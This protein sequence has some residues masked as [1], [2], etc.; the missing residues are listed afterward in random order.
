M[1]RP[2]LVIAILTASASGK[3]ADDWLTGLTDKVIDD[4]AAGKPLVVEVHVP[5]CESSIIACGNA[6]LGD[7]DNPDTNLYWSTTPGFGEWFARRGSGWKRV[8]KQTADATG[9]KDV[10]AVH[11]YRRSIDT[12]SAWRKRGV[13]KHFELD[14]VVHGWRGKAIDRALAAYAD[15]VS[16]KGTRA[17]VLADNSKLAAGGSAQLV[18]F[19]GHNRLMDLDK[20]EWPDPG[21]AVKGTIAIACD[22][23]PYMKREVPAAT[24]VPLLMTS[25]LLFAN[26][27]PLEAAVLAF[28]TGGG[29]A[30]IRTDATTA[31]AGVQ[32]A[33]FK[34]VS[35][36]FTNPSDKRWDR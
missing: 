30:Q 27:A 8:L 25:D 36:V 35:G 15:D 29:Y 31:Y 5:L 28:A 9:D 33:T 12:P 3:P 16:G 10:L 34:H 24:R 21:A 2:F 1:L 18:A 14:I 11:V 19:V 6:K 32:N 7:G 13:P 22:T 4:L 26:A 17:L 20:F 23:A